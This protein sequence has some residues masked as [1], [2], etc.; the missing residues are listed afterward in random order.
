MKKIFAGV[1]NQLFITSESPLPAY[2][3]LTSLSG[4][5]AIWDSFHWLQ[6]FQNREDVIMAQ[7]FQQVPISA[8]WAV[9]IWVWVPKR[10]EGSHTWNRTLEPL[11]SGP[12]P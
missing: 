7:K 2:S 9:A 5:C 6:T 4:I 3:Q 8:E 12:P 1:C 10:A 11:I